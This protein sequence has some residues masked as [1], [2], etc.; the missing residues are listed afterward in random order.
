MNCPGPLLR[1][2]ALRWARRLELAGGGTDPFGG[3]QYAAPPSSSSTKPPMP[4]LP[5]HLA[6]PYTPAGRVGAATAGLPVG[7]PKAGRKCVR[8]G[9][10]ARFRVRHRSPPSP[11]APVRRSPMPVRIGAHS[12][13][14]DWAAASHSGRR[15]FRPALRLLP[16]HSTPSTSLRRRAPPRSTEVPSQDL[17]LIH[18]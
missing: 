13:T 11:G 12:E 16:H 7:P 10:R 18:I 4:S 2:K 14:E 6:G 15:Q 8:A 5:S 9:P 17:S 3:A 1:A